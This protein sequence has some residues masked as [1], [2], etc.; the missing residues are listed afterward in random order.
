M[1]RRLGL[2]FNERIVALQTQLSEQS[3]TTPFASEPGDGEGNADSGVNVKVTGNKAQYAAFRNLKECL[4]GAA[5]VITSASTIV[6]R[7]D[8]DDT[9]TVYDSDFGDVFSDAPS[10]DTLDWIKN[11]TITESDEGYVTY[12]E[13][14]HGKNLHRFDEAELLGEPDL[15]LELEPEILEACLEQ[16][17]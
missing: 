12:S 10:S 13:I 17:K 4:K 14:H 2:H 11:N 3:S 7:Q 1:I 5:T 16:G 6:N 15:D 8:R 9:S